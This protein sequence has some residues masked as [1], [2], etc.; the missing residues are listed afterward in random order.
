MTR[1]PIGVGVGQRLAKTAKGRSIRKSLHGLL[2]HRQ[3]RAI[4]VRIDLRRDTRAISGEPALGA[5]FVGSGAAVAPFPKGKLELLDHLGDGSAR[6]CWRGS[7]F[8]GKLP[9][10]VWKAGC[11]RSSLLTSG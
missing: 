1:E 6:V 10:K 11:G 9:C 8:H 7:G 4:G 2:Q 5:R 3:N